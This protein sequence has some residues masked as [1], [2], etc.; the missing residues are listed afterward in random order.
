MEAYYNEVKNISNL[1]SE[2]AMDNEHPFRSVPGGF[3]AD[4][5]NAAKF[6]LEA[7]DKQHSKSSDLTMIEASFGNEENEDNVQEEVEEGDEVDIAV[8]MDILGKLVA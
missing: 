2:V 6:V 4:I 5:T 8:T 1:V 3:E 7:F